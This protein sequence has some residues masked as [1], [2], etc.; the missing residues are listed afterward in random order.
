MWSNPCV[1]VET[2]EMEF[3]PRGDSYAQAR[4]NEPSDPLSL[5]FSSL[6]YDV[7][8]VKK[9]TLQILKP[10]TTNGLSGKFSPGELTAIMGPSGAGKTS[11]LNI[12]SG[13]INPTSGDLFI[14]NKPLKSPSLIRDVSVYVQ[15][16]DC[17]LATQTVRE[18][19][20]MSAL[21]RL[22][23]SLSRE[24]KLARAQEVIELFGLTKCEAT[25]IGDPSSQII[26]V[27]G[28][29]RKRV[30][31]AMM[32]VAQ[33]RIIFLD[34]PTS[35]LDSFIAFSVIKIMKKLCSMGVTVIT[36]IHQPSSDIFE[37]F[38]DLL[39]IQSGSL[40]YHGPCSDS[41]GH[42]DTLGFKCPEKHNPADFFFMR[43]LT[44][45][46]DEE[47]QKINFDQEER[48]RTLR[49]AWEKVS[50]QRP[51][52]V[53]EKVYYTVPPKEVTSSPI[54]QFKLLLQRSFR[55]ATRNPMRVRAQFGQNLMFSLIISSI[56]FQVSSTQDGIQD[57][58][59]VLFF[60]AANGMMSSIMGVLSTFGN[61][62]STFIRDYENGLYSVGPYFLGKVACDAPFY[63]IIPSISATIMFFAVGFQIKVANYL[64]FVLIVILLN[65]AGM[66]MGLILASI[67]SDIAVALLVAPLIIM[68]LMMFSGFFL[69][70]ESTPAYYLWIPWISPMKYA[71]TALATVE[72]T[73]LELKCKDDELITM[74]VDGNTGQV[75]PFL[76][77][78][79]FL[80]TFNF[81]EE[82][83]VPVCQLS[84]V[85]MY[86]V[87]LFLA[88]L[89]LKRLV[90]KPM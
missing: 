28:G 83:T 6:T 30:S 25:Y 41:V 21:L 39:L 60:L 47:K 65:Y 70:A 72:Y 63:F 87:C 51:G 38:D 89:A 88:F 42:F 86:I 11:L 50:A 18:T 31:I 40:V 52:T 13:R 16:D 49:E 35:G 17:M 15:Q 64:N 2:T 71:Y 76:N 37:L 61:E 45:G 22:P 3:T 9:E 12:L 33:P 74:T 5:T 58:N 77:G 10:G 81:E 82:L 46:D 34:E 78:E 24:A 90:T 23:S 29:E 73:G 84:L 8:T 66:G 55:E 20:E 36:T 85:A 80:Q 48:T 56:W 57:R 19:I 69:N 68:P 26:G 75:C 32:C 44:C 43:V 4:Q 7:T 62:R 53:T 54:D 59:G 67:F 14:D 79:D 1:F 27:S